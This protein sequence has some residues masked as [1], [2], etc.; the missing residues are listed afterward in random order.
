[1]PRDNN[2]FHTFSFL[3]FF[4]A[5]HFALFVRLC[6]LFSQCLHELF[7]KSPGC[8]VRGTFLHQQS[9]RQFPFCPGNV[10]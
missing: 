4:F 2:C 5:V 3:Y 1:M 6:Y 8:N 10:H 9:E 7:V